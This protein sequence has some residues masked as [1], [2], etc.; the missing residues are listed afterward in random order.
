MTSKKIL[1]LL[2]IIFL[3]IILS[4]V[5][6]LYFRGQDN[7][8]IQSETIPSSTP[9][10][11]TT[12]ENIIKGYNLNREL[13]NEGFIKSS[14][15]EIVYEFEIAGIGTGQEIP[16]QAGVTNPELYERFIAFQRPNGI[17]ALY[18]TPHDVSVTK[19]YEN[20][21]G[22]QIP[23]DFSNLQKGDRVQ[24]TVLSDFYEEYEE[25]ST[26]EL[27]ILKIQN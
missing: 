20:R 6:Y 24:V 12:D 19:I 27:T 22:E 25:G 18:F 23:I 11:L 4:E 14:T 10:P 8:R 2:I 13:K 3:V 16:P 7:S 26:K 21:D 15:T 1:S 17:R 5:F 9:Q